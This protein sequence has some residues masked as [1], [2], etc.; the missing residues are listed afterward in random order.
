MFFIDMKHSKKYTPMNSRIFILAILLSAMLGSC[1]DLSEI[2]PPENI[3]EDEVFYDVSRTQEFLNPAYAGV[4]RTP[5]LNLEYYTDNAVRK[6]RT[7]SYISAE[8]SPLEVYWERAMKYQLHINEFFEKS[9]NSEVTYSLYDSTLAVK[10][11]HR[12]TGE[13]YGLRAY[14]KWELL[15]N[16][17][18][19]SSV[20]STMLG[21]PIIDDVLDADS[22]NKIPRAT[23]LE[24]YANIMEDI[25]SAM[26]YLSGFK[27]RYSGNSDIDGKQFTSRISGEMLVALKARL[28]LYAA[29]PAYQ[30][31]SAEAACDTI[32]NAILYTGGLVSLGALDD[33][34]EVE[35]YDHFW[36]VAY[37][38][39]G[40]MEYNHFPPSLLGRGYCNPTQNLAEAFGDTYGYPATHPDNYLDDYENQPY[41]G[42]DPRFYRTL[43]YNGQNDFK[44]ANIATYVGGDDL[45]GMLT[46]TATRTSY[47]MKKFLSPNIE[48]DKEK[49]EK[50]GDYKVF[51][52]FTRTALYLDYAEASAMA[53]GIMEK[54]ANKDFSSMDAL[55]KVRMRFGSKLEEDYYVEELSWE[56]GNAEAIQEY[57]ELVYN[58]RRIEMAF[59][60]ERFYDVR[61][62]KMPLDY[63]NQ[64]KRGIKITMNEDSTFTYDPSIV[65]EQQHF[66]EYMYYNPIPYQEV[67]KSDAI[68]QNAGW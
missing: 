6:D 66:E 59:E 15:K 46:K 17:A 58:E 8:N 52:V 33:Y 5:D 20:D 64:A 36:R 13:A 34:N 57:L 3:Y 9:L 47:Y 63:L 28:A 49:G 60:G 24:S 48:F 61:R 11:R 26:H 67:I 19:P 42:R 45:S 21:F 43:F 54:G 65:V 27:K 50:T 56:D 32:Y 39:S 2:I 22:L 38:S 62:T 35:N 29:S 7:Q 51:P 55:S 53:Y 18:G 10:R 30:Q 14:Y 31:I 12:L 37:T 68:V 1:T 4:T 44:E 25:D 40:S 23:Y 41:V 16:F